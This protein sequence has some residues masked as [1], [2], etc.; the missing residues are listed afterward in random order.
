MNKI[1]TVL[2]GIL[3]MFV[4]FVMFGLGLFI[5]SKPYRELIAD[6]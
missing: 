4:W 5:A 3:A 6:I 1:A 2:S